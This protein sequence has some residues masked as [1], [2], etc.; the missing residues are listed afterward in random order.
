MKKKT[1]KKKLKIGL[2]I[3]VLIIAGI[4][5]FVWYQQKRPMQ[6]LL[7]RQARESAPLKTGK[8]KRAA[9]IIAFKDFRDEEYFK[10]HEVLFKGEIEMKIV[11]SEKGTAIGA[12]GGEVN[13]DLTLDEL[14]VDDFDAIVFIGG[15][16]APKYLDNEKSYRIARE[17]IEKNKILAAICISPTILAK[18]G[19]LQ[20]KKATVWASP[21][22]RQPIK[23]LEENGAEYIDEKVVQDGKI[24]TGNGPAAAEEFGQK[25]L[26]LL[27]NN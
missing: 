2:G 19:V 16:G 10:T 27:K 15:P 3:I 23:I 14:K 12:D 20:G 6:Q 22:D 4:L 24:I 8:E 26:E 18:A 7:K 11:S 5:L 1:N 9:I 13:I 25:I 17:A 21:L